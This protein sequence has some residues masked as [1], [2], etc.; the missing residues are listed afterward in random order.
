MEVPI[1]GEDECVATKSEQETE[2]QNRCSTTEK[3]LPVMEVNS[4]IKED[5]S[6]LRRTFSASEPKIERKPSKTFGSHEAIAVASN[7]TDRIRRSLPL[8][9]RTSVD[10]PSLLKKPAV[11]KKIEKGV[12]T[13]A[14]I[15]IPKRPVKQRSEIVAAVTKRLYNKVKKKEAA[16]ET[17]DIKAEDEVPK[18]LT[19]CSNARLRLQEIT[20]RAL[21]AHRRRDC[22]TQTD[23]F[24]VLR[25]KEV[26]TDADD[27]RAVLMEVKD[28]QT[29]PPIEK[30]DVEVSC[31][32]PLGKALVM[33]RSC[34]TQSQDNSKS[35]ALFTSPISFTKYLHQAQSEP[36]YQI[37]TPC[38]GSPIYTSSVNINV[39]HN[40]ADATKPQV[41]C[42]NDSLE[43]ENQQNVC[44]PTP[45]LISNH[46]SL[47]TQDLKTTDTDVTDR[48]SYAQ[49]N[50]LLDQSITHENI[51]PANI[52]VANCTFIPKCS[53]SL[54]SIAIPSVCAPEVCIT[55]PFSEDRCAPFRNTYPKLETPNVIESTVGKTFEPI[56]LQE[57]TILK[58]I[59]KQDSENEMPDKK[60]R[61]SKRA[62]ETCRMF[63]AMSNFLE[64]AT[65]LIAN[66]SSVASRM[67]SDNPQG[68]DIEVTVNESAL[69]FVESENSVRHLGIQTERKNQRN[70]STQTSPKRT[71]NASSYTD[72]FVIPVNRFEALVE[73]SCKRLER[74]IEEQPTSSYEQ[75]FLHRFPQP[76]WAPRISPYRTEDSSIE[77]TPT[78]SDYGSLP[79]NNRHSH[80]KASSYSPS[81]LLRHLTSMRQD[82][83]RT[84]R[85][86]LRSPSDE[87]S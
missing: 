21:R 42:C 74:C 36:K 76:F 67:E 40:Y 7:K 23:L 83:I 16:T 3:I 44:F 6:S 35:N 77:S 46:N 81:A 26:S 79:R 19:I 58:S 84:S 51:E 2:I 69:P 71:H 24:P 80:V 11:T 37:L 34:A 75:E 10:K 1:S 8:S 38:T 25:V 5:K 48:V 43:D 4:A 55:E 47:D 70:S 57:A 22:E 50:V 52:C 12:V 29:E 45:D 49:T 41:N 27:L 9:R 63:K 14:K 62:S 31:S 54:H 28:A 59:M 64:E 20:R 61:F 65:S 56:K 68:Y 72:D 78:F 15:E 32:L 33:T 13:E 82:I 73:D 18:E 39:S 30:K 60:V 87:A 86:E 53:E 66:L 85:E 17:E